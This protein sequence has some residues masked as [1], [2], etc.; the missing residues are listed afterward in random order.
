MS[1]YSLVEKPLIDLLRSYGYR[2][3]H[4]RQHPNLRSTEAEVLFRPDLIQ[5]LCK[6]NNISTESAEQIAN[7]LTRV[8]DTESWFKWMRGDVSK[9]MAGADTHQTIHLVDF[10]DPTNNDW[11]VTN[12][13]RVQ[14]S[15]VRKPDVVLY[16]NGF[17]VVTIECKSPLNPTQGT[18]KA[19]SQIEE[20][21]QLIPRLFHSNLFNVATNDTFSR[22]AATGAPRAF[23][24]NWRDPWP[25]KATDFTGEIERLAYT[26]LQ[27]Q[28]I[29]DFIAHFI[30]F[31]KD[32]EST[33]TIKKMCRH[34]QYRAVNKMVQR[35][36]HE[37]NAEKRR[38]LIW[39]TQGSGK[40]L[41]MAFAALKLKYH[42]GIHSE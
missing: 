21:E 20:Q 23:W 9:K 34:Q 28:R 5:A 2:Y 16:L 33:K 41:T 8:E 14:G 42:R 32:P 30:V 12:Q 38:G 25:K 22:Y 13:L 3:V 40:S 15:V 18:F 4:H 39:H 37:P 31:E 17:P 36:C 27:P 19:I 6:L 1:E 26:L 35:V 11:V 7:E 29:L 24:L 10:D